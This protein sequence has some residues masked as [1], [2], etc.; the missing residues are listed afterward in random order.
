MIRR[1]I[2]ALA[3]RLAIAAALFGAIEAAAV[4]RFAVVGIENGTQVTIRLEH[5]WG[6]APWSLDV[7]GPGQRK[8]FWHTF[9][10]A[11]EDR[12]PPFNVRFDSD[13]SAGKFEEGYHL[14]LYGAP[15]HEWD[16]AHKYVF[17]YDAGR[18]FVELYDQKH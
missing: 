3:A 8:L 1:M 2:P 13:L 11:N 17:K 14:T 4:D 18:K 12:S 6:N 16:N 15:A 9:A 5:K 7:L 10:T